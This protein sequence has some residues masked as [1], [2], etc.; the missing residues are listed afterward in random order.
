MNPDGKD[1]K[2]VQRLAEL[3]SYARTATTFLDDCLICVMFDHEGNATW[4]SRPYFVDDDEL[5]EGIEDIRERFR[6][7]VAERNGDNN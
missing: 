6:R 1:P 4:T 5:A 7:A 3:N 2:R